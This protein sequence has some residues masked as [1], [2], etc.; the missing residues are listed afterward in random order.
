MCWHVML[1]ATRSQE[2]EVLPGRRISRQKCPYDL[3][4]REMIVENMEFVE[5]LD[6]E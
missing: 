6:H 5:G 4:I 3:P 2:A 1:I